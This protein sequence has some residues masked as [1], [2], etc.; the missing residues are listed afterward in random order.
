MCGS[1][2]PVEDILSFLCLTC[3]LSCQSVGVLEV[4]ME[5]LMDKELN[6]EVDE[7]VAKEA[8][9]VDEI[10]PLLESFQEREKLIGDVSPDL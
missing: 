9:K 2:L 5:M 3:R 4:F 8:D 6:E 10:L 7:D 1:K